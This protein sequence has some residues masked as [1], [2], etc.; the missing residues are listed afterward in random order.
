M[1]LV[2]VLDLLISLCAMIVP[3]RQSDP[4]SDSEAYLK[5][6]LSIASSVR[7]NTGFGSL[8]NA[9]LGIASRTLGHGKWIS[10]IRP[11][12]EAEALEDNTPS[13]GKLF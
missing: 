4:V 10:S 1:S 5:R 12:D 3:V 6:A 8:H 13:G 7:T 11:A 2:E 9:V